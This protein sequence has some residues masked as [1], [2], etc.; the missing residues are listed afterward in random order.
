MTAAAANPTW[1][2]PIG[3]IN[4]DNLNHSFVQS[5]V[6]VWQITT[7]TRYNWTALQGACVGAISNIA[8]QI[9]HNSVRGELDRAAKLA[10]DLATLSITLLTFSYLSPA[11]FIPKNHLKTIAFF[12]VGLVL[13]FFGFQEYLVAQLASLNL[14]TY[15]ALQKNLDAIA[16]S[17]ANASD[18]SNETWSKFESYCQRVL[19]KT[20]GIVARFPNISPDFTINFEQ[21]RVLNGNQLLPLDTVPEFSS[22]EQ[23]PIF[24]QLISFN[25]LLDA[26]YVVMQ[27]DAADQGSPEAKSKT[28][29]AAAFL[30]LV[31]VRL[32]ASFAGEKKDDLLFNAE[33]DGFRLAFQAIRDLAEGKEPDA[34]KF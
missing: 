34:I 14:Y 5:G 9:F 26:A 33:N 6:L 28:E 12:V 16:K 27:N 13:D 4:T 10:I 7:A 15:D 24:R 18:E 19:E 2:T 29:A 21:I 30:K 11:T 22:L 32:K 20:T 1:T 8:L 17:R 31:P 3:E 23:D 25:A